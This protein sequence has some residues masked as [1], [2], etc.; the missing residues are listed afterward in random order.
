MATLYVIGLPIGNSED[1]TY[2]ALKTLGSINVIY[3][4]DTRNTA[5][6]FSTL[7]KTHNI[8]IEPHIQ[9]YYREKEFSKIA[10]ILNQLEKGTD[11][12]LVSDAGMPTVSDPGS[13]LIHSVQKAGHSV[14]VIPGVSAVTTAFAYCGF[15]AKSVVFLGFL[16]R[17]ERSILGACA[18]A[19]DSQL[20]KP[21]AVIFFESARNIRST[22]A[23]LS[24]NFG[25]YRV[26]LSRNMTKKDEVIRFVDLS[27]LD[28][29]R[30]D[31]DGE[32]TGILMVK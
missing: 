13:L 32:Y 4:E 22:L 17:K 31:E 12:G 2:R 21:L 30:I 16:P 25:A 19:V 5:H 1:I 14:V 9:S 10:E 26:C 8:K 23:I 18:A 6:L 15:T 27:T 7:S 29:S 28:L 20:D 24:K 3:A 11:I